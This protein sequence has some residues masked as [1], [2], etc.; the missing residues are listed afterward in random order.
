VYDGDVD[1]IYE[2]RLQLSDLD[3][4]PFGDED[5]WMTGYI[6]DDLYGSDV[7]VVCEK[8]FSL[9]EMKQCPDYPDEWLCLEHYDEYC[10][11]ARK[12]GLL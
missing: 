8:W 7:C 11:V 2:E 5:E 1:S 9:N 10:A 3:D 4:S 12:K 6:D